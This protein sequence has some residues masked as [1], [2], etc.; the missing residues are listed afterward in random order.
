MRI[1]T[2][3]QRA[4]VR[5]KAFA[6]LFVLVLS[7]T[8]MAACHKKDDRP[9]YHLEG[10][11]VSVDLHEGTATID[12]K[13]IPGYMEAMAM[14]YAAENPKDLEKLKAGDQITADLVVEQGVPLLTN[15]M[16]TQKA[17]PESA[18]ASAPKQ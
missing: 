17:P 14:P 16:V 4:V 2:K 8:M 9:R 7:G 11:V 15:I 6:C 1:R 5:R 13:A 10:K 3:N 18:P 12:A